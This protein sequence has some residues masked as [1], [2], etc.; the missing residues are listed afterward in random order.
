MELIQCSLELWVFFNILFEDSLV[1]C[2]DIYREITGL[3]IPVSLRFR[4]N[5]EFYKFPYSCLFYLILVVQSPQRST[6]DG[7]AALV[8][9]G[10]GRIISRSDLK[11]SIDILQILLQGCGGTKSHS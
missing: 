7:Y 3:G 5:Q 1:L 4:R 9:I 2:I 11:A 8:G 6:A 10:N